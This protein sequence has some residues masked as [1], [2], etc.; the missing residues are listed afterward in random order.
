MAID[1]IGGGNVEPRAL[2]DEMKSAYLDYAMSVIVGRALPDVRDGLKPVHRRVLFAMSESG[3]GPTRPYS[4]CARIVGEV[5]GNYHPHGDSSIYD[6]LV[7]MAQ[8]FS[9]RHEL[10][11]GQGNF[12]SIDDDPAA[13]MRY[14]EARMTRLATEMLRDIDMDTVDFVPNYDGRTREPTVLPARFPN[15]LVNGSSGIAVGMATNIPPHNLG[16]VVSATI[17]YI[18]NP[19][20]T[21]EELMG[22]IKG[23]D[24]PTGGIILGRSGI[25]DAYET[26]RGRVRVR[27]KAHVEDIGRGK[28]AIIVTELPYAVKKGG[29][30]GLIQKIAALYQEKKLP[31]ISNVED[32]SSER[33]GM[34]LVIELKR[35]V[36]P[37]VA[38]NKLYKHTSMQNTFGV[39]MVALVDGVPKTLS[40]R[41]VI[42]AYVGHQRE[43][44][45]RRTKFELAQKEARAHVLEGLLIALDN[46]DAIIELIRASRDRETARTDLQERFALSLIQATAILDLRL[47][48]LTALES[49]AIKQEHADVTERIAELRE[50][51]GDEGRVLAIIK[52]ELAEIS[53]RFADPRRTE[54]TA[55]EDELD[56][57]DLIADQQMVITITKTGYIKSLPL[58]TYRQQQ[59][60]GRGVTGMDMK[61]GDY[62]E[63]LFVC[64]SHDFLLFFSNRGKVYRQK[65][66][67]LPE[68]QRTAKGRALVNILPL[69]EGE[70]IQSVVSTR[71]FKEAAYL[72]FATKSGTVKKTDF[73]AYNTPIKADGIIAINIRDDDEL[74]AVRRVDPGDEIIMVSRAGLT[75]RFSEQD[76]RS[77]GRDTSGVRGMDVGNR[78]RPPNEVI[79]MDVARDEMELL[80]VTENG[81]GKRTK[82]DQYRKTSRGAKGVKTIG[83][84]ETK[85]GLAGALVVRP[86]QELVFISEGGMVQRTGVRPI[87]QQGR[88][89][90][91]VRVMNLKD[92]DRVSAAALVVESDAPEVAD[93][94][95][96]PV[97]LSAGSGGAEAAVADPDL[98]EVDVLEGDEDSPEA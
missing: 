56:I 63:H 88:S 28:E 89:A 91:G 27:A 19:S 6:T 54:I 75:V 68:A 41:E 80:V 83:L 46:L 17:A 49:D 70:R 76:A 78:T 43:V 39:N 12:G 95:D 72:I 52:E 23:P 21:V 18:D 62:I 96:G 98:G 14:T 11:D 38:L 85:G 51:L 13:A 82:I 61:D 92:N 84:T 5:M 8:D 25:R 4:K 87:S 59:R 67:D 94:L 24:F 32:H 2:E 48:Q 37:K 58:A 57:E 31:E 66:Y 53:E 65:V 10:V 9:M 30:G 34:R 60:G 79:A 69:R 47:S 36:L 15:L 33:G 45:V 16:E 97:D 44:I 93:P 86:H 73:L 35:D 90:T 29:E 81:Y 7:R 74:V 22:H 1:V 55:S 26:G 42:G 77:M 3:M 64:S 20:I 40:L 71:D 50:I